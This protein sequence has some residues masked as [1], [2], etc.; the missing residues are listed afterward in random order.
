MI[1]DIA[2]H[3]FDNA[4]RSMFPGRESILLSFSDNKVLSLINDKEEITL[5]RFADLYPGGA[6]PS[7]V[8]YLFSIDSIPYF[9]SPV[10]LG[11]VDGYTYNAVFRLRESGP[12][13]LSFAILTAYALHLWYSTHKYCGK[14]GSENDI[15]DKERMM[16]CPRC[17]NMEYPKISP[18]VIVGVV[19]GEKILLSKYAGREY[20]RH[21]L[22]A[23]FAESG[24]T[25][26]QTVHR[27]VMEEVGVKVK[28][29][30]YY[31]SQPWGLSSS[32]L[33]GFFAE[34]DGSPELSVDHTEL[35]EAK[36]FL[37][38]EI[39]P[40]ASN[41]SLTSEMIEFFRNEYGK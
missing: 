21:A 19:D 25:I 41:R 39:P 10:P 2:P 20:T 34:L 11:L 9:L 4:Y 29:L 26:E 17:G 24:E 38:E 35:S 31:K 28:N 16:I 18:A 40:V 7:G 12:K 6:Y 22:L 27:E 5:P 36:W 15:H 30:R 14:C 23:G 32:L 3:C 1:Q 13:H 8:F 37:R 33:F